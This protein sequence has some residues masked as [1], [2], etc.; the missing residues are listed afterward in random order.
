[1]YLV[2]LLFGR[3]VLIELLGLLADEFD[4]HAGPL[5]WAAEVD[6]QSERVLVNS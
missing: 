6:P 2:G 5:P 4:V 3:I 1:M